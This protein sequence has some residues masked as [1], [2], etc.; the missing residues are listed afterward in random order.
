MRP[1]LRFT[2][3]LLAVAWLPSFAQ[4]VSIQGAD[5]AYQG[6]SI[7][8][9]IPGNPFINSPV[10]EQHII[11]DDT[12]AFQLTLDPLNG[13]RIPAEGGIVQLNTGIYEATLFARPGE[14]YNVIL[15]PFKERQYAE[16]ISPY[17][18]ILRIPLKLEEK[19]SGINRDLF[20][21]DSIFFPI[22]EQLIFDRR[23]GRETNVD[24]IIHLLESEYL[25]DT[26]AFFVDYRKYKYGV[27]KLNQGQTALEEIG[28]YYLG[29]VVQ[30]SH[31]G[32]MELFSAMYK[33]FLFYYAGTSDGKGIRTH[34]N[35]TH[36]LDS[37]RTIIGKHPSIWDETLVDMILLEELSSLFYRGDYHKEAILIL[38]D[39]I[40]S[41]PSNVKMGM[42]A[43]QLKEKLSSLVIGHPPPAFSLPGSDGN[44]YQLSDFKDKYVFL[45]FCTPDHYGCMME[46]PYLTSYV[47]KHKAYLEVITIMVAEEEKHVT[48][49]M[50]RNDYQWK[51]LYYDD[52]TKILEDYQVK[53]FPMAYLIGPDGKLVLSPGILPTD[54]FEQQLFRIMRSRGEI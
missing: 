46:Y 49:F 23:V 52:Q 30:E 47:E 19:Q 16:R 7:R 53:A 20:H 14:S 36:N 41:R 43:H 10:Y 31:P 15:P 2:L 45:L 24:S 26:T 21:F 37:I 39:S 44:M 42:Y 54:G 5:P 38:L 34:I 27:L 25:D 1:D 29:P 48:E 51:A 18:Q 22:N 50:T 13:A 32:F 17:A 9:V 11:C 4:T 8:I 35:R 12:G 33:D 3:L 6:A 40:A 28:K